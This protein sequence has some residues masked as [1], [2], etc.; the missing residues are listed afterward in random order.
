[1]EVK[2][3]QNLVLEVFK[4]TNN[5]NPE[6]MKEIF[7]KSILLT[8]RPL[9]LQVNQNGTTKYSTWSLRILGSDIW[10]NFPEHV[11]KETNYLKFKEFIN[12]KGLVQPVNATYAHI[13]NK[14]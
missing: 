4:T 14:N 13:S 3:L 9:N 10:N 11:K 12:T 1:M 7:Y 2:G 6:Y 8:H 5:L